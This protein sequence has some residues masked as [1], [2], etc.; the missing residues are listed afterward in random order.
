MKISKIEITQFRHLTNLNFDFGK[1]ITVIAGGNGTGKTSLLGLI[2]HIFRYGNLSKNLF[3]E[4]YE[5]KYS[6]VFRFSVAHDLT[7]SYQ[8][9]I[10]FAD[11]SEKEAKLRVI[12]NTNGTI[13]HRIDVGGRVRHGGK[14]T[15]PVI[16][17][18]LKRLLPLAQESLQNIKIGLQTLTST[19]E[20][21]YSDLYNEV[22]S[23]LETISP[24]HTKSNNKNSFS[25]TTGNFDAHGISAGQDNIGHLILALLSFK[26][27]KQSDPGNYN[28][29]LLLIDE[30]DATLYPA[31][32][33]NLLK[34]LLRLGRELDLQIV[35]TTHSSDIL[36][37]LNSRNGSAFKHHTNFVSLSNSSGTV[38]ARQGFSEL[39]N[40]LADLNH[41]AVRTIRPKKINYYFE[42]YEAMCFYKGIIEGEDFSCEND[43]KNMSISCGTY[44]T[45]IDNGF[46]EFYKSVV[47]LDGDFSTTMGETDL[48]SI[49]LLPGAVRPENVIADFLRSL[50]PEDPFWN[51][52]Y[53]YTKRV[54]LNNINGVRD[55]RDA[56]KRWF[57]DQLP[58]WGQDGANLFNRWK[59]LNPDEANKIIERTRAVTTRILENFYELAT[60]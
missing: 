26:H 31:S 40:L 53:Q 13:R 60:N 23:S 55:D 24:I 59:E 52:T 9:K 2:G 29:G 37:F 20:Q 47:V 25:P 10:I 14:I 6:S 12:T 15:K 57:N 11:G 33:I 48:N 28:G 49:V 30:L 27:L 44:K 17:L 42:D 45:L 19:Q 18:S 4:R 1:V 32:Q 34:I 3:N 51:N 54:F 38:T 21:E 39:T 46:E 8:Y 5:T 7:G 16:F 41:A 35:F 43:F 58:Y 50:P 36:N 22:F 56:M